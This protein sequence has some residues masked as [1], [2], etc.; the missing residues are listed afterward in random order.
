MESGKRIIQEL[1]R[2]KVFTF[3]L[4]SHQSYGENDKEKKQELLLGHS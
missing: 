3:T 4:I 2:Q 1:K